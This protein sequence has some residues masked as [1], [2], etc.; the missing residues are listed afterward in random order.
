MDLTLAVGALYAALLAAVVGALELLRITAV[1]PSLPHPW[2][3][4]VPLGAAALMTGGVLLIY[5]RALDRAY[6]RQWRSVCARPGYTLDDP[7]PKTGQLQS[8]LLREGN[9]GYRMPS[10][11]PTPEEAFHF[12]LVKW[13]ITFPRA[14][15]TWLLSLPWI[16]LRMLVN[17]VTRGTWASKITDD[18]VITFV[19]RTSAC[20][21]SELQADGRTLRMAIPEHLPLAT[22]HGRT[23]GGFEIFMD[24]E[25][26]TITRCTFGGAS[27]VGDNDLILGV[28]NIAVT[29]WQHT[30]SHLMAEQAVLEI[31]RR[32]IRDLAPSSRF[33]LALHNGL[34]NGPRSPLAGERSP[35]TASGVLG[36]SLL[37]SLPVELPHYLDKRKRRFRF[38]AFLVDARVEVIRLLRKHGYPVSVEAA[39]N[40]MVVHP[41]DH[42]QAV[43]VIRGHIWSID[44][45]RTFAS[46]L[47]SRFFAGVMARPVNNPW[48][49]ERICDL[50]P[51]AHPFYAELY[52][53]LNALD[54][55]YAEQALTSC[56][57]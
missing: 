55:E 3:L 43:E 31:E 42:A 38:Y 46:Y 52:D 2:G 10:A 26:R 56:S 11:E 13:P 20:I 36:P 54:G 18:H 57:F 30:K 1:A 34:I 32:G 48:V 47:R 49:H 40:N 50:D 12:N 9:P 21:F 14:L 45:S 4:A 8:Q 19:E 51:E 16:A 6:D 29:H 44:M 35:W 27:I 25:A 53:R 22:W 7:W 37:A 41:V 39:F 5:R 17:K 23:I 15:R 24:V 33:T 28:L